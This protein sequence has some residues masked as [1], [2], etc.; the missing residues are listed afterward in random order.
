[1]DMLLVIF[2]ITTTVGVL[3]LIVTGYFIALKGKRHWIN[4]VD[5]SKLANPDGFGKF[6]G[7]SISMTGVAIFIISLLLYLQLIGLI[8]FI[9]G[10]S[11]VS[12]LPLPCLF[13]AKGKYA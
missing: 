10:L 3:P 9:V 6:V 5:Q 1:M 7:H 13:Y 8:G 4:G 12:F 2:I 11:I